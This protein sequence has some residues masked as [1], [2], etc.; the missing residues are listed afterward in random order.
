MKLDCLRKTGIAAAVVS[1]I[2]ISTVFGSTADA[3]PGIALQKKD[4]EKIYQEFCDV[5]SV[6]DPVK[7]DRFKLIDLE[8]ISTSRVGIVPER[9]IMSSAYI[10]LAVRSKLSVRY[11]YLQYY[12]VKPMTGYFFGMVPLITEAISMGVFEFL[13]R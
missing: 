13:T 6:A 8:N 2:G 11:F 4:A 1:L 12:K 3:G 7:W 5:L 9:G 10:R